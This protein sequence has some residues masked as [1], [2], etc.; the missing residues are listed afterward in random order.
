MFKTKLHNDQ[1][2]TRGWNLTTWMKL[3]TYAMLLHI[4]NIT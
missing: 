2:G 3:I 4:N 1:I